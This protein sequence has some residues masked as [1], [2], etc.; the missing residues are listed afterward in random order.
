MMKLRKH[1]S[2]KNHTTDNAHTQNPHPQNKHPSPKKKQ[3]GTSKSGQRHP[4]RVDG[5]SAGVIVSD[6]QDQTLRC[7][8]R[9]SVPFSTK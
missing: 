5:K 3:K 9:V 4:K 2:K 7:A 1:H 8:D 6:P